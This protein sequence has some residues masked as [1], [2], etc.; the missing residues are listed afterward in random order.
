MVYFIPAFIV[1]LVE[2]YLFVSWLKQPQ[3]T[4]K[5]AMMLCFWGFLLGQIYLLWEVML[6]KNTGKPLP[7][8]TE[9][10]MLMV[11]LFLGAGMGGLFTILGLFYVSF[12]SFGQLK[13]PEQKNK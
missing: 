2:L 13:K 11:R 5:K 1:F 10:N 8:S 6:V 12:A 7:G 4:E 3:K 9:Q